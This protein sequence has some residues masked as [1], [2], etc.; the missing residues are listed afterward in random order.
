M[1]VALLQIFSTLPTEL[2]HQILV[3]DGSIAYRNGKYMNQLPKTDK[4]FQLLTTIPMPHIH[5]V[6][7]GFD[8]TIRFVGNYMFIV[9]LYTI[10]R[11]Y[12]RGEYGQED[13][14]YD[15]DPTSLHHI[16]YRFTKGTHS[17]YYSRY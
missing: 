16:H 17:A 13:V 12:F 3:Y 5:L 9:H 4:R 6:P 15:R 2:L 7:G 10:Q 1:T 11:I 14:A 8:A